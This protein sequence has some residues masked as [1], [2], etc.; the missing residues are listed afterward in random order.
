MNEL[1]TERS[2]VVIATEINSIKDQTRQMVLQNS[3]EIGKRLVEAKEVV[4][5]G[6][7]GKWLESSVDYSQSTAN[8]LMKIYEEYGDGQAALFGGTVESEAIANLTYTQAVAL[9]NIPSY[10]REEFVEEN[11]VHDLS[12]RQL[13]QAIKDKKELEE[14]LKVYET[15]AEEHEK[16][17]KE[18][19]TY[20]TN[21]DILERKLESAEDNNNEDA[22]KKIEEE[23]ETAKKDLTDARKKIEKL[24]EDLKAKPIDIKE[25]VEKVP[26]EIEAELETLRKQV[27]ANASGEAEVKF[28]FQFERLADNFKELLESLKDIENQE[29]S[30]KYSNAVSKLIKQMLERL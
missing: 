15:E 2:A 6:E 3:I 26:E 18:I 1:S 24:E 25:I 13:Q 29:I 12:T 21:I 22:I 28:K 7:W 23:A 17:E 11:N 19:G 10:E 14:K 20:K 9:F 30:D 4:A 16:L 8:N 5:H 27:V